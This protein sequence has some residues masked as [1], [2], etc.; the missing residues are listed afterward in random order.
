MRRPRVM[1]ADDHRLVREAF[2]V[3]LE[4]PCDVVVPW[5]TDALCSRPR[6]NS[7]RTLSCSTSQC[8]C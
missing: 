5:V 2:G 6:P 3:L 1:L 7:D 8:P 4:V